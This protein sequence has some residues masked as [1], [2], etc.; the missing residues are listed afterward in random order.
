MNSSEILI[1]K[2]KGLFDCGELIK[3]F[4]ICLIE[5]GFFYFKVLLRESL[6]ITYK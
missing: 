4:R 5:R 1:E 2:V 3:L 6:E